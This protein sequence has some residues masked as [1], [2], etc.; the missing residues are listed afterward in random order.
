M[1]QKEKHKLKKLI[2]E[3]D[4]IRGRHTELIS[5]Y[6]PSG[7]D[8]NKVINHLLQE[9]GTAVNIK[10][11]RTRKN[12]IDSLERAV[13]H[14]RLY[15][16]TPQNGLALFS[17]NASTNESK[18]D[19]RVWAYEP[20][21]E[22]INQRIYR[23]DQTFVTDIL[24]EFLEYKEVYG[25]IVMDRREATIGL[26]RGPR[27]E[28]LSSLT[29][30]VPGKFKAGGQSSQR[31]A[32]LIEGMAKEF[33]KRVADVCNKEFLGMKE[34]KGI[35]VG[36]PGP[37]KHDF[38]EELN[39]QI[40]D[41]IIGV[42]D[43]TYT[44]ESG[45]H[46][47]VDKSKEVLANEAVTEEKEI[48]TK[49][50]TMLAKENSKTAYGENE[51]RKALEYGAVDV[52]LISEDMQDDKVEEFEELC[53]KTRTELRIISTETREGQ[54]LRDIGGIAAILRF[55]LVVT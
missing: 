37:T 48:M 4:S 33:Y 22:K 19:L 24:K 16:Q 29:S 43:L 40:K 41:K 44:D 15:K 18:V 50:F 9:Q 28:V 17:G 20:E 31:F 2:R 13:R 27:I 42:E 3:L 32:R 1:N 14:L 46:H 23:C 53:S 11:A 54:Q 38:I 21:E 30:G 12:V 7:Y 35:L 52:L 8:M 49:F 36:G 5:V 10:D 51:V 55:P 39:Q 6:V 26:L 25:L 45:L 47:L 34:L